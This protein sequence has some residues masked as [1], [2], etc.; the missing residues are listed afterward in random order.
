MGV[1]AADDSRGLPVSDQDIHCILYRGI[2]LSGW[3]VGTRVSDHHMGGI[4]LLVLAI[5]VMMINLVFV[6][7]ILCK[8]LI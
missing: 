6:M 1:V 4:L 7:M 5:V 3:L 2:L 8:D